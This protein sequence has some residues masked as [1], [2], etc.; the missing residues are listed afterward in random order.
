MVGPVRATLARGR[1]LL[2]VEE[3]AAS[4]TWSLA[5][6]DDVVDLERIGVRRTTGGPVSAGLLMTALRDV[7]P[8][9]VLLEVAD[10]EPAL[11]FLRGPGSRR[12]TGAAGTTATVRM[13]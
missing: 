12:S 4:A 10:N 1:V 13:R 7:G 8:D 9:R 3:G 6:A 5:A 2:V 11:A